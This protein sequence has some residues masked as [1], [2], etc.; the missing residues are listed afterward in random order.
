[1]IYLYRLGFVCH[2]LFLLL[3]K[4]CLYFTCVN[5]KKC[6]IFHLL[7]MGFCT[8]VYC[9]A[10][11]VYGF[12]LKYNIRLFQP[13][14]TKILILI[15]EIRYVEHQQM[16]SEDTIL[17]KKY[18][19]CITCIIK[20]LIGKKAFKVSGLYVDILNLEHINII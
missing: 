1:M 14:H 19:T 20:C 18:I 13:L 9:V 5:G 15:S 10:V 17:S 12:L 11:S 4:Y 3:L 16:V 2:D 6:C 7:E 8:H